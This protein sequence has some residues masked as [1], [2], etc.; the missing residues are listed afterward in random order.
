LAVEY[1]KINHLYTDNYHPE[2]TVIKDSTYIVP[3][4][5]PEKKT[6]KKYSGINLMRNVEEESMLQKE[7]NSIQIRL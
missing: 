5:S 4:H 6:K 2:N 7:I 3:P 1:I